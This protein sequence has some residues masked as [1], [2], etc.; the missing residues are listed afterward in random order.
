MEYFQKRQNAMFGR[1]FI[2]LGIQN[3][4]I[5][6]WLLNRFTNDSKFDE[7]LVLILNEI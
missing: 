3:K 4:V 7:T 5:K 2:F 6:L 1:F